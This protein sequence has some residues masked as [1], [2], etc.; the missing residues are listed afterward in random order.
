MRYVCSAAAVG[1]ALLM[2]APSRGFGQPGSGLSVVNYSLVG[3]E[4]FTRTQWFVT[5][6]ADIMNTGVARSGVTASASSVSPAAQV[7]AGQGIL[8][9]APVPANSRVTSIDTFTLLVDRSVPFDFANIVWSFVN[10]FANAGPNQTAHMGNTVILN[11]SGS[12]DPGGGALTYHWVMETRPA[13]SHAAVTG[14]TSVTASFVVDAPGTYTFS[15]TVGNGA[16][17]DKAI[18]TVTT[19]NSPPV[20]NA[21]PNQ[22]VPVNATVYLNGAGSSDVDGDSLTYTW[23]LIS[24]PAGSAAILS[25]LRSVAP[26]FLADQRG[27]YIVQLVVNDGHGDSVPATV[28][29]NTGNT[30]PVAKAGLPQTV[31][32]GALVQ[33]HGDGSTDVDGDPLTYRWSLATRPAG[34]AATLNNPAAVNPTFTADLAGSYVAQLIVNDGKVDSAP[35]TV[36]ITVNG[37]QAPTANA[38]QNQTVVHGAI[39]NLN[40]SGTDPQSLPLTYLWSLITR[41]DGSAAAISNTHIQAPTFIADRPGTYVAQ[42]VVSNQYL[43]SVPATV[44]I[45]T[46]NTAPVANAGSNRNVNTNAAVLLDGTGSFDADHDPLTYSWSFNSRPQSSSATLLGALTSTPSFVP[47]A[48]GTYVLQ[49]IVNDGFVNSNPATVTITASISALGITLSPNPLNLL[50]NSPGTLTV[51]LSAPAGAGGAEVSFSG[52]NAGVI[53]VPSKVVVPEN[54]TGANVTVTPVAAGNTTITAQ[55]TG[56]QNAS[57]AVNVTAPVIAM[58]LDQTS[59]GIGRAIGGTLTLSAPAPSAI[60]V[61]LQPANVFWCFI[62]CLLGTIVGV[63]PGLGPAATIAMLLPLTYKM[64]PAGG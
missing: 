56:Y 12:A 45:T 41:P 5:Y 32:P 24:R 38:G 48:A 37:Y 64:D 3:E 54:S 15:L 20:A 50:S 9:F 22:S 53:S 33:L 63:L 52:F 11:G 29:I 34:S 42:L 18:T 62:G 46:T 13:A 1:I 43:S 19:V 36:S 59:V 14:A 55:A 17:S 51:T 49:L 40:G 27:A 60:Q 16:G 10:P 23:T 8:H 47:D 44:T 4:R 57:A 6:R 30:P 7:V 2:F 58:T 35:A 39:V 28:T 61:A 31:D 21:G 26:W 25:N